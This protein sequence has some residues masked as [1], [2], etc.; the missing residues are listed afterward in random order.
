MEFTDITLKSPAPGENYIY[1]MEEITQDSVK[2]FVKELKTMHYKLSEVESENARKLI[3]FNGDNGIRFFPINVELSTV[4]GMCYVGFSACNT[5]SEISKY[6]TVNI[7]ASGWVC[8]MGIPFLLSVPLEYRS[9]SKDTFFMIHQVS[10]LTFGKVADLEEDVAQSKRIQDKLWTY[11]EQNSKIT[12]E[13]L[14][15][16]YDHKRDWWIT[17]EE[18]LELGLIS[19]IV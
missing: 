16:C 14:Q 17:A 10:S 5:L 11:I 1:Y 13:Q 18:A 9:A 15:D 4:G 12:K 19:K 6:R 8:S 7:H 3:S 2:T